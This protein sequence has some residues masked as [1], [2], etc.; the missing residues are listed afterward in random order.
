VRLAA[1]ALL[2]GCSSLGCSSLGCSAPRAYLAG[3]PDDPPPDELA[4][5]RFAVVDVHEHAE[6]EAD[7]ERLLAASADLGIR[8]TCVMGSPRFTFQ[9]GREQG[10]EGFDQNNEML[11]AMKQ[12]EPERLCVFVTLHPGDA[13]N[14][15]RLRDYVARGADGL[16]LFLGHGQS[17]GTEPFHLMALDDE[18]M[19]PVY[20]EAERSRLPITFHVNLG[21]YEDELVRVLER[22]PA[23]V[24]NL[25]HFGLFRG[26]L[27][28]LGE[29]LDRHRTLYIDVSFGSREF[30]V[31]GFE[32]LAE[33]RDKARA[34]ITRYADRV[35]F[36]ADLVVTSRMDDDF[37]RETLASYVLMLESAQ[38]RF[39]LQPEQPL[40]GLA[41]EPATLARVYESTPASFL[42]R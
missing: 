2:V 8:R 18:R 27:G 32:A 24:V 37:L 13:G 34:F 14:V 25:P 26:R 31:D 11:L 39:F 28:R 4:P 40:H 36:G 17:T 20:E 41:L 22:F 23:L 6:T 5:R 16:K 15:E 42:G 7:V 38:F 35:L 1:L 12:R 9:H 21:K 30:H 29:L 3:D 10:F 33:G 19:W